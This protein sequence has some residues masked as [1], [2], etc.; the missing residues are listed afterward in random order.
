MNFATRTEWQDSMSR[1]EG[2]PEAVDLDPG[3]LVGNP[4]VER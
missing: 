4:E 2:L 3:R 1:S